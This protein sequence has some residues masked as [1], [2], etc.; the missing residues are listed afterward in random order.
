MGGRKPFFKVVGEAKDR[1]WTDII[2]I[3]QS[4]FLTDSTSNGLAIELLC[5]FWYDWPPII[6][7]PRNFIID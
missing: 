7:N 5:D 6:H 4:N 3:F 2:I 1:L